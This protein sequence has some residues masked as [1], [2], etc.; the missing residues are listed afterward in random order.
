MGRGGR[1]GRDGGFLKEAPKPP[2]TFNAYIGSANMVR[3]TLRKRVY[4]AFQHSKP[5]C[6]H[7]PQKC[8]ESFEGVQRG[9]G[10]IAT[11]SSEALLFSK[12]PFG[13]SPRVPASLQYIVKILWKGLT[14]AGKWYTI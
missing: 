3:M 5:L 11:V 14:K 7:F 13:A 6:S 1:E 12:V 8:V 10:R 2:R 4:V 9:D